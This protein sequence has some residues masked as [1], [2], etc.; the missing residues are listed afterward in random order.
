MADAKA[1][2]N[3]E[4]HHVT[5]VTFTRTGNS[6]G[7]G[8]F[9]IDYVAPGKDPVPVID[10]QWLR[11]YHEVDKITRDFDL[12]YLP[13]DAKGGKLVLTLIKDENDPSKS[14]RKE[15]PFQ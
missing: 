15:I 10:T 8:K 4:G 2:M 13:K 6:E 11:I 9:S 14:I 12:S 3:A 1:G 7:V 5:T